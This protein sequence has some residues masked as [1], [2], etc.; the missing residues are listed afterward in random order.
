MPH[1]ETGLASGVV[2]R[3]PLFHD[4][5]GENALHEVNWGEVVRVWAPG[6]LQF[7]YLYGARNDTEAR[8]S[9][10]KAR[11]NYLPR[12]VAGQE[13]RLLGASMAANLMAWQVHLQAH[14]EPN[15]IDN[16]A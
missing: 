12:D 4:G 2:D 11:M 14:E 6:S 9:D 15:V 8:H 10:L 5:K 16:T 3:I 1:A 7:K 13:L